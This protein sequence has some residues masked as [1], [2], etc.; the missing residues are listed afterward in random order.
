MAMLTDTLRLELEPFGVKVVELKT[1]AVESGFY[2][3]KN[4]S[5]TAGGVTMSLPKDS[6]YARARNAVEK[7]MS[8]DSVKAGATPADAWAKV[9]AHE[10]L[11]EKPSRRIWKGKNASAVWIA[12]KFMPIDFLDGNMRKLGALQEV[13]NALRG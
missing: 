12:R 13:T 2:E 11:T 5:K 7:S 6:L 1:G 8:G 4:F 3:N 9:V 10:I